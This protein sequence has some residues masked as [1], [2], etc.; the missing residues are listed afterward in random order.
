MELKPFRRTLGLLALADGISTLLA[1]R[2]YLRKL[3]TGEPLVDDILD[4][5]AEN[6]DLARNASIAEILVGLWLAL[7]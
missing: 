2:D 3:R 7:G 4:F 5:L 1:P 6:P